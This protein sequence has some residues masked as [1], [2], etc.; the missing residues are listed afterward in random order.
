MKILVTGSAGQLAGKIRELSGA[1]EEL[2]FIFV[3]KDKLD[4]TD[5]TELHRFFSSEKIDILLNCAA[6]TNV[7]GAETAY[8][9]A[10]KVNNFAVKEMSAYLKPMILL[11]FI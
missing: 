1:T 10:I 6:Y 3:S 4:I 11:L 9:Q 2:K 8:Q 7:D 5:V